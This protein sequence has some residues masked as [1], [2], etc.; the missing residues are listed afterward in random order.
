MSRRR[1]PRGSSRSH[2]AAF[3]ALAID[4]L[5]LDTAVKLIGAHPV[6]AYDAIQLA[7]AMR[8]RT[9]YQQ[10]GLAP[11]IFVSSDGDMHWTPCII[12]DPFYPL[13]VD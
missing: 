4:S 10:A 12:R 3:R 2:A 1:D 6:R 11:P 13:S 5:T 9:E 8:L 7:G